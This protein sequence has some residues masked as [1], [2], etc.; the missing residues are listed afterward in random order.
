MSDENTPVAVP[1]ET[2]ENVVGGPVSEAASDGKAI[3]AT[4]A[5]E[6]A[7]EPAALPE[8]EPT[9]Q[10]KRVSRALAEMSRRD[11]INVRREQHVKQMAAS[12]AAKEADVS[13][14]EQR[15]QQT[16]TD[17]QALARRDPVAAV[18]SV[19][20]MKWDHIVERIVSE[21]PTKSPHDEQIEDL[22]REIA[23]KDK[24]AEESAR[25]AREEADR[26][27]KAAEAKQEAD[28]KAAAVKFTRAN[29]KMFPAVSVY[30][31]EEIAEVSLELWKAEHEAY[32]LEHRGAL[33]FPAL[34]RMMEN[35]L[36]AQHKRIHSALSPEPVSPPSGPAAPANQT[37]T[38]LTND[39]SA[40]DAAD[41]KP[42][43]PGD[44]SHLDRAA[45][46]IRLYK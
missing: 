35:R 16:Q 45:A 41:S 23:D 28:G 46:A 19:L 11:A 18:E 17:L 8:P 38:T 42:V 1:A 7:A 31:D 14:R 20:G 4:P 26:A 32:E 44:F 9:P 33:D 34:F 30:S 36:V 22:R 37:P 2:P 5:T 40:A 6:L 21:N 12:I 39:L 27:V 43:K 10:E 13:T 15:W 3:E 24:R 25:I 29:A